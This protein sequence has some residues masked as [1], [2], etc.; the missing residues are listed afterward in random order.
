MTSFLGKKVIKT[1][2]EPTDRH[3]VGTIGYAIGICKKVPGIDME[4]FIVLWETDYDL[5]V[6]CATNRVEVQGNETRVFKM[7]EKMNTYL[8][9]FRFIRDNGAPVDFFEANS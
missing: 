2:K 8:Q 7:S 4:L 9:G 5:P 3:P 6:A 1:I